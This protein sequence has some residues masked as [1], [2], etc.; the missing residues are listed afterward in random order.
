VKGPAHPGRL[1]FGQCADHAAGLLGHIADVE[2]A[3]IEHQLRRGRVEALDLE[4]DGAVQ[5][6]VAKVRPQIQRDVSNPEL[7]DVGERVVVQAGLNGGQVRA[8]GSGHG[9]RE[10]QGSRGDA[11]RA[12]DT[13]AHDADGH[14]F[15]R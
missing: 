14:C 8:G 1:A 15:V 4:D 6:L 12:R 2:V 3:R 9:R 5:H 10:R 13:R 11:R 7:L